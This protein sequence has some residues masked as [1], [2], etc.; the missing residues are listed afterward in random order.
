M[1]VY[2]ISFVSLSTVKSLF[3][4][5]QDKAYQSSSLVSKSLSI[6]WLAGCKLLIVRV[7]Y[8]FRCLAT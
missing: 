6:D 5:V 3:N 1:L 8:K 7:K 2:K 4:I